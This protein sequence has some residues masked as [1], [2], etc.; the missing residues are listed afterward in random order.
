M[1][2]SGKVLPGDELG[3]TL[4]FTGGRGTYIE[5]GAIKSSLLGTV[6][7]DGA[8]IHVV[9]LTAC[10]TDPVISVGDVVLGRVVKITSNQVSIEL[11]AVKDIK[12]VSKYMGSIRK[13]DVRLLE[14]ESFVMVD[15]FQLGDIVRA[16]VLSLGD[17][18]QYFL[19]TAEAE[20]G[21]R[22]AKSRAGNIMAPYSWKVSLSYVLC[23]SSLTPVLGNGRSCHAL[24]RE[25]ESRQAIIWFS[26][27]QE[28]H[29]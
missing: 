21:V 12:L 28:S 19:S 5:D 3:S 9:S 27:N 25:A 6:V 15:F 17:S 8:V 23:C 1:S 18:R 11:L 29:L 2:V 7:K 16:A 10:S 26:A 20:Y 22:F 13:E 24:Q 14:E 4:S